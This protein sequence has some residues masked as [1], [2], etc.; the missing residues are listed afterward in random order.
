MWRLHATK[1]TYIPIQQQKKGQRT[2]ICLIKSLGNW[3]NSEINQPIGIIIKMISLVIFSGLCVLQSFVTTGTPST[4]TCT[5]GPVGK[6]LDV[7]AHIPPLLLSET[8]MIWLFDDSL[9]GKSVSAPYVSNTPL[10]CLWMLCPGLFERPVQLSNLEGGLGCVFRHAHRTVQKRSGLDSNA[11][12]RKHLK[13]AA[14]LCLAFLSPP[15]L[16][17][18]LFF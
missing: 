8:W 4:H 3:S 5:E 12:P 11:C 7:P 17:L 1:M 15:P 13:T 14:L 9:F 16:S 10:A 6:V 18:S 2:H